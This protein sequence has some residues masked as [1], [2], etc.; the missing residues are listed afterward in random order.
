MFQDE[1]DF[2]D[3]QLDDDEEEYD[4]GAATNKDGSTMAGS[5]RAPPRNSFW[6]KFEIELI[7]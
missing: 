4:Y 5:K 2:D 7:C 3:Y 6:G 1:D